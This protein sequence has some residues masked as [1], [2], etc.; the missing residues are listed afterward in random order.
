LRLDGHGNRQGEKTRR[1][2]QSC[3]QKE[4]KQPAL[5]H[6]REFYQRGFRSFTFLWEDNPDA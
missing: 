3:E 6:R 1:Q 2:A 4:T 5:W